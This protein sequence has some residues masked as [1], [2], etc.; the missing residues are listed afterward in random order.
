[1][2]QFSGALRLTDLDDF[3]APSQECIKPVQV[4]KKTTKTKAASSSSSSSSSSSAVVKKGRAKI[5]IDTSGDYLE[6]NAAT[7]QTQKLEKASITLADCLACS[8]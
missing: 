8:G 1:M 7:G 6:L 2:S 4:E 3:I 5:S